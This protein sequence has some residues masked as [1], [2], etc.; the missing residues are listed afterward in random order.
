M[1]NQSQLTPLLGRR[2]TG[3]RQRN[4]GIEELTVSTTPSRPLPLLYCGAMQRISLDPSRACHIGTPLSSTI[5][6]QPVR[7]GVRSQGRSTPPS[8]IGI[9]G[10]GRTRHHLL[11][12]VQN[13]SGGSGQGYLHRT[14]SNK[15]CAYH[16]LCPSPI[17]ILE[18]TD[19]PYQPQYRR[20]RDEA[21][22]RGLGRGPDEP[23]IPLLLWYAWRTREEPCHTHRVRPERQCNTHGPCGP[24]SRAH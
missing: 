15:C 17:K 23:T 12:L 10:C 6:Y 8:H 4:T 3:P 24:P 21:H 1:D 14:G 5:P 16:P 19:H 22:L 7:T 18:G 11:F 9:A 2:N 20:R 13:S